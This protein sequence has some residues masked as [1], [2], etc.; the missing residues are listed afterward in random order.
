MRYR[1]ITPSFDYHEIRHILQ[2]HVVFF[3]ALPAL[4]PVCSRR[5]ALYRPCARQID[6]VLV[7]MH[8]RRFSHCFCI[9]T[10]WGRTIHVLLYFSNYFSHTYFRMRMFSICIGRG[11]CPLA[12]LF[13]FS[14]FPDCST[15]YLNR[16][17]REKRKKF[18]H[19]YSARLTCPLDL[20]VWV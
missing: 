7:H 15:L 18:S 9:W 10:D 4:Q 11:S 6:A 13:F 19:R 20:R 8:C 17:A 16:V 14:L 12:S 2:L 3:P 1:G 5:C